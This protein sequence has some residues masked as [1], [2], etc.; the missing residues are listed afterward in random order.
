MLLVPHLVLLPLL[1]SAPDQLDVVALLQWPIQVEEVL[2]L[3]DLGQELLD[4]LVEVGLVLLVKDHGLEG[5]RCHNDG[6]LALQEV[7]SLLM[8]LSVL[9]NLVH[10]CLSHAE[11]ERRVFVQKGLGGFR[12]LVMAFVRGVFGLV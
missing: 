6:Q 12:L 1:L 3:D 11:V 9:L 2:V 4:W 10:D 8:V 5:A 7:V